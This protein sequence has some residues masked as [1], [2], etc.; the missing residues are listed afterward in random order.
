MTPVVINE[1]RYEYTGNFIYSATYVA[2]F[3]FAFFLQS[4][5]CFVPSVWWSRL[6][7][8]DVTKQKSRNV[9]SRVDEI[10]CTPCRRIRL[11]RFVYELKRVENKRRRSSNTCQVAFNGPPCILPFLLPLF[12]PSVCITK[13]ICVG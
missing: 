5:T 1:N 4:R 13:P 3:F 11:K 7:S 12:T 10:A 6:Y 9:G 2:R 8:A